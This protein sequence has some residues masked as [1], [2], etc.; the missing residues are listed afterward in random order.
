[1][2]MHR[3]APQLHETKKTRRNKIGQQTSLGNNSEKYLLNHGQNHTKESITHQNQ[4]LVEAI[5]VFQRTATYSGDA[6][7]GRALEKMRAW[8]DKT[9]SRISSGG[10]DENLLLGIGK[11]IAEYRLLLEYLGSTEKLKRE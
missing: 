10:A 2:N 8:A 5:L 4:E 9:S 3:K 1:M 11:E 6:K 7:V